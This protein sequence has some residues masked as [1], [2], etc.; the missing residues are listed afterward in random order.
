[1]VVLISTALTNAAQGQEATEYTYDNLGRI[2]VAKSQVGTSDAIYTVYRYDSSGN[3]ITV[4]VG[5]AAPS[6]LVGTQPTTITPG[7]TLTYVVV[8]L[9]GFTLIPV[10][11]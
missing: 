2:A 8:P 7:S 6:G 10:M 1:M 4:S 11:R 5:T 3:R 9:N